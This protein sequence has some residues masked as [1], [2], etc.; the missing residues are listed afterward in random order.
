M[1]S[2]TFPNSGYIGVPLILAVF[3]ESVLFNFI[4][5]CFPFTILTYT[6]GIYI[7]NPNK[8]F[9]FKAFLNP[10]MLSLILGILSGIFNIKLPLVAGTILEMSANCMAPAAMILTGI[11]FA[12]N[13]LADMLS[14][15]KIYIACFIKII[16]IP[17]IA[18]FLI[19]ALN[20]AEDIAV[21]TIVMLTLPTGLNSI[22]FPEAY[23]GDG[24]TG[25][26][27]CFVSTILC[28]FTIPGALALYNYL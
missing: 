9:N 4:V 13:N 22:I 18:I 1:Y 20:L 16:V 14:N 5:Y 28:L 8:E 15:K 6:F 23:G 12:S 10:M 17:I 24:R 7:L 3:G 21:M 27:L 19:K 25:A 26:Q 11:V 2:F